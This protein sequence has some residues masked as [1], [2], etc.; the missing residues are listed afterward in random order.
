M[1][2]PR[3]I[4]D[5]IAR[6]LFFA[7]ENYLPMS[8][9]NTRTRQAEE[10]TAYN[11]SRDAVSDRRYEDELKR[12]QEAD[13]AR[14]ALEHQKFISDLAPK[15]PKTPGTIEGLITQMLLQGVGADDPRIAQYSGIKEGLYKQPA[16]STTKTPPDL[17]GQ[18]R[19]SVEKE[20]ADYL[21]NKKAYEQPEY[22][23]FDE[24]N[25]PILT[26]KSYPEAAPD[27]AGLF[28]NTI[29]P[30]AGTLGLNADS[31]TNLASRFYPEVKQQ[32]PDLDSW[33]RAKY[34]DWD[35]LTPEQKQ[36]IYSADR[37]Q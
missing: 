18:F 33:G 28:Q 26:S 10:R 25:R 3:N 11:R 21:R 5:A 1:P 29:L 23:G 37:G 14:I 22:A 15:E 19:Q 4:G 13:Q 30:R 32:A 36:M 17:I 35:K 16:T 34:E 27:V 20:K 2:A 9:F 12:R 8:Q 6:S 31:L 24:K 7:G